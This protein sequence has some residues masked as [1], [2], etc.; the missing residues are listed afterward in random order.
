MNKSM[1][2]NL[3]VIATPLASIF[4]SGFLVIV[5]ILNGA[6]GPYALIAM[7]GICGLAYAM[8]CVIRY[9]IRHVEPLLKAGTAP[10]PAVFM[11]RTSD[12]ALVL[13]YAISVCLYI[14]I[15]AAFLLGGLG[16]DTPLNEHILTVI[17]ISIIGI[18]G[19]TK[20]LNMLQNLEKVA[21]GIT[22]V[23]NKSPCWL[24]LVYTMLTSSGERDSKCRNCPTI[25][26]GRLL[27]LL[28]EHSLLS[29]D[30][31]PPAI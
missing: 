21:L 26:G 7:A 25:V 6:V 15:L 16:I 12:F 30:L 5:P 29:R 13:T 3:S 9:N 31:K 14:R 24:D 19:Y 1:K 22:M 4:G 11:E 20:G 23:T 10:R 18:I 2:T 17:V 8:G 28:A 27:Q